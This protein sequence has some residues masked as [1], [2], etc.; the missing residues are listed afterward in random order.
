MT[1]PQKWSQN[2]T[3]TNKGIKLASLFNRQENI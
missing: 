3:S 2:M 1:A